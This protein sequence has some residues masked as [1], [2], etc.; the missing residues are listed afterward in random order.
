MRIISTKR[1]PA[2]EK[3][4][5]SFS[6]DYGTHIEEVTYSKM[7]EIIQS[8]EVVDNAKI[9]CKNSYDRY[10]EIVGVG[11]DIS[12]LPYYFNGEWKNVGSDSTCMENDRNTYNDDRLKKYFD[13]DKSKPDNIKSMLDALDETQVWTVEEFKSFMDWHGFEYNIKKI[14]HINKLTDI[15]ANCPV[16][17]IPNGI[18]SITCIYSDVPEYVEKIIIAPSVYEIGYFCYSS[19]RNN[20]YNE[21]DDMLKYSIDNRITLMPQQ[22]YKKSKIQLNNDSLLGIILKNRNRIMWD[23]AES[24]RCSSELKEY[25]YACLQEVELVDLIK[26]NEIYFQ[27]GNKSSEINLGGINLVEVDKVTIAGI[28]GECVVISD[29][30]N[31]CKVAEISISC[32]VDNESVEIKSSFKCSNIGRINLSSKR[33]EIRDSFKAIKI[34]NSTLCATNIIVSKSFVVCDIQE[35]KFK[36]IGHCAIYRSFYCCYGI[37][38]VPISREHI[39]Q[40]LEISDSFIACGLCGSI[41]MNHSNNTYVDKGTYDIYSF[42]LNDID[43]VCIGK[44]VRSFIFISNWTK[45]YVDESID[46][47][48]FSLFNASDVLFNTDSKESNEEYNIEY[49][50]EI[51]NVKTYLNKKAIDKYI[52]NGRKIADTLF[53]YKNSSSYLRTDRYYINNLIEHLPSTLSNFEIGVF[54]RYAKL[55]AFDTRM[56]PS[57]SVIPDLMFC[58]SGISELIIGDN[59]TEIGNHALNSCRKLSNLI[60]GRNVKKVNLRDITQVKASD[61]MVP[62]RNLYLIKGSELAD[63]VSRAKVSNSIIVRYVD[64]VEEAVN[65]LRPEGRESVVSKYKMLL[66]GTELSN[67]LNENI[68]GN[69]HNN[70]RFLKYIKEATVIDKDTIVLRQDKFREIPISSVCTGFEKYLEAAYFGSS[71]KILNES[72]YSIKNKATTICN[73]IT[74]L[75]DRCDLLYE[76][77]F[78]DI[79]RGLFN[80]NR[81]MKLKI[82]PM[83]H[84]QY[85]KNTEDRIGVF[86]IRANDTSKG[87]FKEI[88]AGIIMIIKGVS[89]VYMAAAD[90]WI[91]GDLGGNYAE[92]MDIISIVSSVLAQHFRKCPGVVDRTVFECMKAGDRVASK[93]SDTLEITG[94]FGNNNLPVNGDVLRDIINNIESTTIILPSIDEVSLDVMKT[95]RGKKSINSEDD[96]NSEYL[97][98]YQTI[99][100]N[101]LAVVDVVNQKLL[102]IRYDNNYGVSNRYGNKRCIESLRNAATYNNSY[103]LMRDMTICNL[104]MIDE[105]SIVDEV[106][107]LNDEKLENCEY[108][109]RIGSIINN[110]SNLNRVYELTEIGVREYKYDNNIGMET[111]AIGVIMFRNKIDTPEKFLMHKELVERLF[112][113]NL[114]NLKANVSLNE[115]QNES[116]YTKHIVC[117]VGTKW[118]ISYREI[119]TNEVIYGLLEGDVASNDKTKTIRFHT[120]INKLIAIL[121]KI[122]ETIDKKGYN[123][124]L[125]IECKEYSKDEISKISLKNYETGRDIESYVKAVDLYIRHSDGAII[126]GVLYKN[127]NSEKVI[128][129]VFTYRGYAEAIEFAKRCGIKRKNYKNTLDAEYTNVKLF[130]AYGFGVDGELTYP[131]YKE[132]YHMREMIVNGVGDDTTYAGRYQDL[133]ELLAKHGKV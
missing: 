9:V 77:E 131:Q 127:E 119:K 109:K 29:A 80:G 44:S 86:Y 23:R 59:I 76:D 6:V 58:G 87:V 79:I 10:G 14:G 88:D 49:T 11:C 25:S 8:G 110:K 107:D 42:L 1:N 100:N 75:T 65:I 4:I 129:T 60:I 53:I 18:D 120:N 32:E 105:N 67:L 24:R 30:F 112:K 73:M 91:T 40:N 17:H 122:G 111:C 113:T 43:S 26:V 70:Y 85:G 97:E 63:R 104:I 101:K 130:T 114:M 96:A 69:V 133:W 132:L 102:I 115:L 55:K 92:Y 56:F 46:S 117:S 54:A 5:I 81:N 47:I 118:F 99:I 3:A 52:K 89:I 124:D 33:I 51:K 48:D 16:V 121:I 13:M 28:T 20:R 72:E 125:G 31:N 36:C 126:S 61:L 27:E 37:K 38:D 83:I 71:V 98:E 108:F 106:I 90:G 7:R 57:L 34:S 82:K 66:D 45:I 103:N 64:S 95:L 74:R 2:Y 62:I 39:S 19:D 68:V 78:L 21:L 22:L 12:S 93:S 116:N 35:L 41:K 50:G 84:N 123:G 15:S 128:K 94:Y